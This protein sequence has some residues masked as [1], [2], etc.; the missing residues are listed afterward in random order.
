MFIAIEGIDGAGCE[1]QAKN[2]QLYLKKANLSVS[3]VKYPNY[4]ENVGQFI[5]EF[6]YQNKNLSAPVQF[7]LYTLQFI[8]DK[9]KIKQKRQHQI[10]IADRYFTTTLCFQTLEG[11]KLKTALNFARDFQI[12]KPDLVFYLDVKPKIA[13]ERKFKEPKEKNRREK[14]VIFIKKTYAQYQ[15]LIKQQVWTKWIKIN[16]EKDIESVTQQIYNII[17]KY[18]EKNNP[19]V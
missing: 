16:G 7:L 18:Y 11:I 15:K 2:L 10:L 5:Q 13:I 6:L 17:L 14:D 9:E 3:L 8:L 4:Q 12:E 1:T 19:A